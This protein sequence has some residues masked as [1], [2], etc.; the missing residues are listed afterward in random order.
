MSQTI[1]IIE[2]PAPHHDTL[3][4]PIL[5]GEEDLNGEFVLLNLDTDEKYRV[6]GWL[7]DIRP[8]DES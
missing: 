3:V 2:T 6:K 7:V 5:E 8:W 4:G 1:Y